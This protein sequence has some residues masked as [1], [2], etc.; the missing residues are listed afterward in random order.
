M[1]EFEF[2]KAD[3]LADVIAD[4]LETNGLKAIAVSRRPFMDGSHRVGSMFGGNIRIGAMRVPFSIVVYGDRI[5]VNVT[6]YDK[7]C[8]LDNYSIK[9]FLAM[10]IMDRLNRHGKGF[11]FYTGNGADGNT[12]IIARKEYATVSV[13]NISPQDYLGDIR[14]LVL[15]VPVDVVEPLDR[16][17]VRSRAK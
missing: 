4:Y 17:F 14:R 10:L 16:L 8:S 5:A 9:G 12:V 2:E 11:V 13:D 6:V 3:A 1:A 7:V 15:R